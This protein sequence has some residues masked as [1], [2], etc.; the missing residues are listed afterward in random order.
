MYDYKD[1]RQFSLF[2]AALNLFHL[3]L[4]F[5]S[6][7]VI[8]RTKLVCLILL[9]YFRYRISALCLSYTNKIKTRCIKPGPLKGFLALRAPKLNM[10]HPIKIICE[11][12]APIK[13]GG[14]IFTI[15]LK[16]YSR[17]GVYMNIGLS[18]I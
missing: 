3:D 13:I 17:V 6:V 9:K 2:R 10:E 7:Y 15:Y 18:I 4:T 16:I 11:Y 12:G 1:T 14:A 5:C 8:T